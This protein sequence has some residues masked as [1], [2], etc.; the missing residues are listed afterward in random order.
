MIHGE[1][2]IYIAL[3]YWLFLT[4]FAYLSQLWNL[5]VICTSD[6]CQFDYLY[7]YLKVS[8]WIITFISP[9]GATERY[10]M[11]TRK[12]FFCVLYLVIICFE[13]AAPWWGRRR[14]RRYSPPPCNRDCKLS[15]WSAWSSCSLPCGSSGYQTKERRVLVR[16]GSCG[17]CPYHLTERRGCN[18]E[19]WRCRNNGRRA[20]YGCICRGG[21]TGTC[22]NR[23]EF[24]THT[25]AQLVF[26][27][28]GS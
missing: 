20:Y 25:H 24:H 11:R 22:C 14:R 10:T 23:G 1:S 21:W 17:S 5:S 7:F 9:S 28:K 12:T 19:V 4:V 2:W 13:T 15:Y 8:C 6:W 16:E 26:K 3:S 18:R 27:S